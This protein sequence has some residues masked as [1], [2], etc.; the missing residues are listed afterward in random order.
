MDASRNTQRDGLLLAVGAY[1]MW[2]LLP[3]YLKLL[4]GVPAMEVLAHRIVWSL[5]LLAIVVVA[6]RRT[7]PI[8]AAARG[9]TLALLGLSATL[10]A[11]NWTVYIWAILSGHMLEGSLGYF[12]NP[13][14][15]VALGIALLGE[16]IRPVQVA[17]V[18]IALAGVVILSAA[19]LLSGGE[20]AWWVPITL[21]VS[22]GLYGLV[23][24]VVAIDSLGGLAVETLLLGPLA[25]GWLLY[26][27]GTGSGAFGRETRM[28]LLLM[29]AGLAT[30]LPLLL[31]AAAARRLRYA[32]MGLLQY[33]APTL[34]FLE[35]V[36]L[37]GEPLR[38]VQLVTFGLIWTGCAL[39]AFD[40]L[41]EARSVSGAAAVR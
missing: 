1:L 12:I 7:A 9:K 24:K 14:V 38:P 19:S 22:F 35:A 23:R 40:S 27:A 6:L 28:D 21:A 3:L 31:F 29:F 16:R 8:R 13:L 39:Y 32:T 4:V 25:L 18:C 5:L 15:N 30:A 33:I 36:L 37:Y 17:A 34:V 2:G 41:R 11:V 10:I 20:S 26:V